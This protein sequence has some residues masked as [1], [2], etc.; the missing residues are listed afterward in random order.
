M[1]C[2][3]IESMVAVL[4]ASTLLFFTYL[5][6]WCRREEDFTI[7]STKDIQ[8]LLAGALIFCLASGETEENLKF[9]LY[10]KDT[11]EKR[12]FLMELVINTT[13]NEAQLAMKVSNCSERDIA[14]FI[15]YFFTAVSPII[16]HPV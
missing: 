3:R 8:S 5:W 2:L 11:S 13:T 16:V 15:N 4:Q 7:S 12:I 1:V 14:D 6:H 9:Y 10:A